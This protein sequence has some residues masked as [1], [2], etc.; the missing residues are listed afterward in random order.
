MTREWSLFADHSTVS[1]KGICILGERAIMESIHLSKISSDFQKL[2]IDN[3]DKSAATDL[4]R[5]V[6]AVYIK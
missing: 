2:D 5:V 6:C 3:R 4:L 1:H